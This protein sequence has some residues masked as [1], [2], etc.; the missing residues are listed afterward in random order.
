M[1]Y[2][3]F[4]TVFDKEITPEISKNG[5]SENKQCYNFGLL[6]FH[7]VYVEN[8]CNYLKY[9]SQIRKVTLENN[10]ELLRWMGAI[11]F[12]AFFKVIDEFCQLSPQK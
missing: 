9:P 4:T 2:V 1:I 6:I 5:R 12:L 3:N 11:F 7:V 8:K 10:C